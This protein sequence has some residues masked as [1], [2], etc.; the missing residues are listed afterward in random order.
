MNRNQPR[1]TT[2]DCAH[3]LKSL[4]SRISVGAI[5]LSYV[6]VVLSVLVLA[7]C[8]SKGGWPCFAW[9]KNT[10]QKNEAAGRTISPLNPQPSTLN[11]SVWYLDPLA[12][13]NQ[14]G[15]S[16]ANAWHSPKQIQG[17]KPG[18]I[19]ITNNFT[20]P[21]ALVPQP[22]P[23]SAALPRVFVQVG[24]SGGCTVLSNTVR[25]VITT[26]CPPP[27]RTNIAV[28]VSLHGAS[29]RPL[30]LQSSPDLVR[31]SDYL[32][33]NADADFVVNLPNNSA[34]RYLRATR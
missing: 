30:I 14:S 34:T 19:I 11:H 17:V 18:D 31:W 29:Y 3:N 13:G 4:R 7:G 9:Q 6:V 27:P 28:Q 1:R 10:D 32:V 12:P 8:A 16:R 25:R 22:V 21:E 2:E 26:N 24:T 15:T 33:T 5:R 20:P 23:P